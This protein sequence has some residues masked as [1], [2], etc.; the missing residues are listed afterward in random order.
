MLYTIFNRCWCLFWLSILISSIK[1]LTLMIS[2][3]FFKKKKKK[4]EGGGP[5]TTIYVF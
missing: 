4:E 5:P 3:D 2:S 1:Y